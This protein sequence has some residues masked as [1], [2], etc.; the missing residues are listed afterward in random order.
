MQVD[1]EADCP[2]SPIPLASLSHHASCRF[3]CCH[4]LLDGHQG[5]PHD[6]P[7]AHSQEPCHCCELACDWRAVS[8]KSVAA[9]DIGFS[10]DSFSPQRNVLRWEHVDPPWELP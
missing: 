6:S 7:Q 4:G 2:L 8:C 1:V 10:A 3:Q 5:P 9:R